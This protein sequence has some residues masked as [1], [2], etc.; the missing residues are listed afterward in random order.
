MAS[1]LLQH[2]TEATCT[3]EDKILS[4]K[5]A[6]VFNGLLKMAIIEAEALIIDSAML[7]DNNN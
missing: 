6:V 5:L 4:M 7:A 2:A 1:K 3:N